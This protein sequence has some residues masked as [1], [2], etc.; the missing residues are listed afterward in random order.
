MKIQDMSQRLGNPK[1]SLSPKIRK[2]LETQPVHKQ[3]QIRFDIK[4][5]D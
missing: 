1:N 4:K 2:D 5:Q 3:Q